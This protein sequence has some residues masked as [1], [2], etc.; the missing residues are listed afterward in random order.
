MDK[1]FDLRHKLWIRLRL[2]T[3]PV[4]QASLQEAKEIAL[5]LGKP[6]LTL[7]EWQGQGKGGALTVSYVGFEYA[8]P[9]L[10]S[11]LFVE[12]P[13]EKEIGAVSIWQL[14]RLADSLD[15]D[16]SYIVADKRL[17]YRLPRQNA[18][19]LPYWTRM[20]L[21]V[22][23]E[24]EEVVQRFSHSVRRNELRLIR[25]YGYTYE[26]SHSDAD[27]ETFYHTMY[28][29]TIT[30]RH[31]DL[32][33]LMSLEVAYQYFQR[34][35]LMLIKRDKQHVAG[36]VCHQ[37]QKVFYAIIMGTLNGDEQLIREGAM[38]TCYYSWIHWAHRQGYEAVDFWG[39]RPYMM[40]LFSYKRKWGA[41]VGVSPDM[42][43][44]IWLR[45][46]H[47]TPAVCQFLKDNPCITLDDKGRLWGLV[48][49]D[50]L[51]NI[52]PGTKASWR[53]Q[54]DT[55]GLSGLHIRSVSDLLSS[56]G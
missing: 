38:A 49:A 12:E 8:K 22:R 40:D 2:A 10:K 48:V 44:R 41:T 13:T 43:Q 23:G 16:L 50:D 5:I 34:G 25:K 42:P 4:L 46:R 35:L 30:R 39:S 3:P 15:T 54:Y 17:V 6:F 20:V 19:V 55:P 36:A 7:H 29:P 27:F 33:D 52:D 31:A 56:N 53:K 21:D 37:E 11:I 9:H 45:I 51:N 24:W 32:A 28:V 14:E 26:V 47:N 1:L 18:L